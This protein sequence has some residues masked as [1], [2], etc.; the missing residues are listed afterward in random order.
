MDMAGDCGSCKIKLLNNK[1]IKSRSGILIDSI[2]YTET[3]SSDLNVIGKKLQFDI[4][5]YPDDEPEI[6]VPCPTDKGRLFKIVLNA[7][8]LNK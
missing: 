2:L 5:D 6:P 3:L 1:T 4:K 7:S 8:E